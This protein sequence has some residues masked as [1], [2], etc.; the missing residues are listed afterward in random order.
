MGGSCVVQ[1]GIAPVL[2]PLWMG[3][4]REKERQIKGNEQGS[5]LMGI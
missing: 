1:S 2:T 4:E 5:R 3:K